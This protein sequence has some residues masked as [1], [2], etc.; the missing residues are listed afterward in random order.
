MNLIL[1]DMVKVNGILKIDLQDEDIDLTE[2]GIEEA[3]FSGHQIN[4]AN[5]QLAVFTHLY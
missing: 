1:Y 4:L 3:V 2:R 5:I